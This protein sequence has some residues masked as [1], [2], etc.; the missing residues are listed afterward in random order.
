[1]SSLFK[2]K[3]IAIK[4]VNIVGFVNFKAK[5]KIV[6]P[7]HFTFWKRQ[8]KH[9]YNNNMQISPWRT[10]SHTITHLHLLVQPPRPRVPP[11][12]ALSAWIMSDKPRPKRPINNLYRKLIVM[13]SM[14]S[15]KPHIVDRFPHTHTHTYSAY[16]SPYYT[17]VI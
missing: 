3:F 10:R 9:F 2:I 14:R 12:S 1:M 7:R 11:Q 13:T 8:S 16:V 4:T 15:Q 5:K 6:L 17:P